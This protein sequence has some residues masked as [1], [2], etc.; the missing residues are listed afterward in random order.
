M[1]LQIPPLKQA[2]A[3]AAV[4]TKRTPTPA[5]K[6]KP[7]KREKVAGILIDERVLI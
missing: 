7:T 4:Q 1:H 2:Q 5:G 3:T 6:P